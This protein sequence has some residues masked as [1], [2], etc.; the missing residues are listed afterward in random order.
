MVEKY[1]L[2]EWEFTV[3]IQGFEDIHNFTP[4][5]DACLCG[6]F[7]VQLANNKWIEIECSCGSNGEYPFTLSKRVFVIHDSYEDFFAMEVVEPQADLIRNVAINTLL[8]KRDFYV[9]HK[10][11]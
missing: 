11:V 6:T 7:R 4:Y 3:A 1:K 2:N 9:N 8:Q 10:S 5:N